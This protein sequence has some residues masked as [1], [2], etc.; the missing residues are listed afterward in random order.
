M[1]VLHPGQKRRST[2]FWEHNRYVAWDAEG[3]ERADL[4]LED[5]CAKLSI[6]FLSSIEGL[7]A[8]MIF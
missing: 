6:L 1:H 5:G 8:V 2:G 7:G 3:G 4:P